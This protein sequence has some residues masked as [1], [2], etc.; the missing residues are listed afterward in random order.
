MHCCMW[1]E[2]IVCNSFHS[3][4]RPGGEDGYCNLKSFTNALVG[5][6]MCFY[7]FSMHYPVELWA[8]IE[9]LHTDDITTTR[10][11]VLQCLPLYLGDNSSKFLV[12]CSVPVLSVETERRSP[13]DHHC[14][15]RSSP[16]DCG[17]VSALIPPSNQQD[18]RCSP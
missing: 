2:S 10:P 18:R 12:S 3:G 6:S 14:S 9:F 17:D 11:A 1:R 15:P 13:R 5:M 4:S 16:P 7:I 8:T